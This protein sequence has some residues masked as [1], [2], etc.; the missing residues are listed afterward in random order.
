MLRGTSV[1]S[2]TTAA[3]MDLIFGHTRFKRFM[4]LCR[5]QE[6]DTEFAH[7][8]ENC[9]S[10]RSWGQLTGLFPLVG[11]LFILERIANIG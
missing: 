2:R 3:G 4:R 5:G 10:E 9:R 6:R 7:E 1:V 11:R 8:R